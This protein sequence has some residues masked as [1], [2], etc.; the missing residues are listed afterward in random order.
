MKFDPGIDDA[1]GDKAMI[2]SFFEVSLLPEVHP[3]NDSEKC[4]ILPRG[5]LVIPF[6]KLNG[7]YRSVPKMRTYLEARSRAGKMLYEQDANDW[8]EA[9]DRSLGI[10]P[11]PSMYIGIVPE[12]SLIPLILSFIYTGSGGADIRWYPE[13]VLIEADEVYFELIAKGEDAVRPRRDL[14]RLDLSYQ[15]PISN[16]GFFEYHGFY[17]HPAERTADLIASTN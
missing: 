13:E 5:E 4:E 6:S 7:V 2:V 12:H 3:L 11:D 9:R 15:D 17:S 14:C 16:W 10:Y 1:T 8:F